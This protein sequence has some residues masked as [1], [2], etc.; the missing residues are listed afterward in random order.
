MTNKQVTHDGKVKV[1][2][3]FDPNLLLKIEKERKERGLT[4]SA[5]FNVASMYYLQK[6]KRE[7]RNQTEIDE[8]NRK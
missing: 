1:S 2:L 5:W 8:Q 6:N 4:R 7:E 3:N